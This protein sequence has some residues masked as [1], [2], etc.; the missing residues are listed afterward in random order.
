MTT[1]TAE[2]EALVKEKALSLQTNAG[3]CIAHGN[4]G[5]C[6]CCGHLGIFDMKGSGLTAGSIYFSTAVNKWR[7]MACEIVQLGY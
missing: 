5:A 3:D 7:C 4:E 1:K 2:Y 6:P